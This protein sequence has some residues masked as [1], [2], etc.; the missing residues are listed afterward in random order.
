MPTAIQ[1]LRIDPPDTPANK[2]TFSRRS[3]NLATSLDV[4][5]KIIYAYV[6]QVKARRLINYLSRIT[7][8]S[9]DFSPPP[10]RHS[11]RN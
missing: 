9:I 2:S 3:G 1:E 5:R 7:A 4:E 10:S 11:I 6:Q 8:S